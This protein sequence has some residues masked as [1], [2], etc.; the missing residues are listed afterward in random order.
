M[1]PTLQ[2]TIL[3]T[4]LV[5]IFTVILYGFTYLNQQLS[6][7][8]DPMK[9]QQLITQIPNI[10]S[11]SKSDSNFVSQLLS[12]SEA[13]FSYLIDRNKISPLQVQSLKSAFVDS[14]NNISILLDKNVVDW[15]IFLNDYYYKN[16]PSLNPY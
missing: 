7:I 15:D 2:I 8:V 12:S 9:V 11:G 1:S 6:D 14:L 13:Y 10:L 4:L 16:D 3:L 5:L